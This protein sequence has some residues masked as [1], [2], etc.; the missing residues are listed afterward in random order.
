MAR[1]TRKLKV[2]DELLSVAVVAAV[3]YL[4]LRYAAGTSG[5]AAGYGAAFLGGVLIGAYLRPWADRLA[6]RFGVRIVPV[7]RPAP[8]RSTRPADK[9]TTKEPAE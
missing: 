9:A 1:R 3:T 4:V 7:G 6:R 8:R 5:A 2:V